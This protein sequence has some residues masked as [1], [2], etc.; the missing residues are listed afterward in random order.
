MSFMT[1]PP[2]GWIKYPLSILCSGTLSFEL[3]VEGCDLSG[4]ELGLEAWQTK[5]EH[6]PPS[7]K[8]SSNCLTTGQ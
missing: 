8:V 7:M 6:V 1:G 2:G 3:R 5:G 4:G